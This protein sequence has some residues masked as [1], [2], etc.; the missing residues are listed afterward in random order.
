MNR[1]TRQADARPPASPAR[2]LVIAGLMAG[3]AASG[4]L[5][6]SRENHNR[7]LLKELEVARQQH[8]RLLTEGN[9]LLL[10][11]SALAAYE[12]VE[13]TAASRLDMRFPDKVEQ[14][15]P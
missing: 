3:A 9:R 6:V 13:G 14:I 8:D 5:A 11:Q 4:L 12:Q 1:S 2:I 7:L 15:A 10:E